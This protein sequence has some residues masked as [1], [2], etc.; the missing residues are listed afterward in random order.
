MARREYTATEVTQMVYRALADS[1]E[2]ENAELE[3][4]EGSVPS[5]ER[6]HNSNYFTLF[7][8]VPEG[9]DAEEFGYKITV[10]RY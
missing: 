5:I 6:G 3:V 2:F 4:M 8:P 1:L 10:E 7:A 9:E